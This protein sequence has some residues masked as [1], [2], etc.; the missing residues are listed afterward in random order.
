MI[1]KQKNCTV[2][3]EPL[4]QIAHE[5][6]KEII[7]ISK[8]NNTPEN[9]EIIYDGGEHALLYRDTNTAVLLSYINPAFRKYLHNAKTALI[10]E[11]EN[12]FGPNQKDAKISNEYNAAIT[13][14]NKLP[15]STDKIITPEQMIKR[16]SKKIN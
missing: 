14:V 11:M 8:Y 7:F 13:R 5:E 6:G 9:P 15:I 16:I 4:Y 3:Q 12:V 2:Y 10:V 1:E